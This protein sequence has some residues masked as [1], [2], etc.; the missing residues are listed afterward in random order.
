MEEKTGFWHSTWL[1]LKNI[2]N[3]GDSIDVV[4]ADK[5]IRSNIYFRGPNIWI[6]SFA[7][8]LASVG[9]NV[10]SI[11]VIIG[12]MLVSPLM[13]PI[14]GLGLGLGINDMVLLR[15]SGKN[16][17]VMVLI[18]IFSSFVYFLITPLEVVNPTELMAR[19]NPTIYDVFIALFGGF[20]GIFELSRK[21][22]GTVFSGVAIATALMPPLCTAGYGLA[23]GEWLYFGGAIYLFLINCIFIMLAT[24]ITV[25]YLHFAPKTFASEVNKKKSKRIITAII[26][27]MVV[28]SIWSAFVM[29][30][31]NRFEQ[32]VVRFV[33]ANKTI[34]RSYIYDYNVTHHKGS[35]VE[36]MISGEALTDDIKNTFYNIAGQ[37]GINKEEIILSDNSL[38]LKSNNDEIVKGIF[39]AN[40]Q[41]VAKKDKEIEGLKLKLETLQ[42]AVKAKD[43]PYIQLTKEI[44]NRFPTVT[45]VTLARGARVAG[46]SYEDYIVCLVETISTMQEK[47]LNDLN[48]ALKVRL[49]EKN[50]I[51]CEVSAVKTAVVPAPVDSLA[52]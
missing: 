35:K 20:A 34:G 21:E 23:N 47:A 43:I 13:G 18:S 1:Q 49:G 50:V 39:D 25:R 29:V 4:A 32:K 12:A 28:P 8:V 44:Q 5:S 9:L 36:F 45:G 3:L 6:L 40:E 27:I 10:N 37:Y 11:P 51:V 17:L 22:K 33:N 15:E 38:E 7:I 19:T 48:E 52:R 14:F 41:R 31:E 16:L 26:V 46:E 42:A 24:Y 2:G 30:K